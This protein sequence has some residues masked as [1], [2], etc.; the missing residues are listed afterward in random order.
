MLVLLLH[1]LMMVGD[2][3]LLHVLVGKGLQLVVLMLLLLLLLV[4]LAGR[5]SL[6]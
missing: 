5:R 4:V 3:L 2:R 1:A 6:M